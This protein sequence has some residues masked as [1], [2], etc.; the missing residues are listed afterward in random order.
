MSGG[1]QGGSSFQRVSSMSGRG[2]LIGGEVFGSLPKAM[3]MEQR[4]S[5]KD[6]VGMSP[7][8]SQLGSLRASLPPV[9]PPID[10]ATS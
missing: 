9:R 5:V 10:Q 1:V 4:Q 2:N 7:T 8:L 3:S 6:T